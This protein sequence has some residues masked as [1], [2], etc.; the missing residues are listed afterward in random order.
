ML[1][2]HPQPT[3]H[4]PKPR[5]AFRGATKFPILPAGIGGVAPKPFGKNILLDIMRKVRAYC[6]TPL[7]EMQSTFRM[8][9]P[10]RNFSDP[11]FRDATEFV[12]H[13]SF[14]FCFCFPLIT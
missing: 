13:N 8:L 2:H 12:L 6:N 5:F 10:N 11:H 1:V 14:C 3:T 7:H 9:L 4:Y